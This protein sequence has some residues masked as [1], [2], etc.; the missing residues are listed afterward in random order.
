[1]K[2]Q[3]ADKEGSRAQEGSGHRRWRRL[4]MYACATHVYTFFIALWGSDEYGLSTA[5]G[6]ILLQSFTI[7]LHACDAKEAEMWN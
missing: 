5:F 1:M 2:T 7:N 6:I 4:G 3:T